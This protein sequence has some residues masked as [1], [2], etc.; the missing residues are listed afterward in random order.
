MYVDFE[1]KDSTDPTKYAW[2]LIKGSDGLNGK[3]GIAG[4]KGEDGKT[5]YTHIAYANDANGGGFS[6]ESANKAY[7][8][9]YVDFI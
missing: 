2:S 5:S 8:G 4:A 3:D 7:M 6:Q 9:V 1:Q